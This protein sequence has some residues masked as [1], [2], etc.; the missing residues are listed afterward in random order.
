MNINTF[1]TIVKPELSVKM[2]SIVRGALVG[3]WD[4]WDIG[5]CRGGLNKGWSD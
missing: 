3:I 2:V 1:P 5:K 4:Y